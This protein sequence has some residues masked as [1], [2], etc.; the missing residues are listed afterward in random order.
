MS[1]KLSLKI[2]GEKELMKMFK[3]LGN[4]R[5]RIKA[6]NSFLRKAARPILKTQKDNIKNS[7][8]YNKPFQVYRK[9]K[10]Y[11]ETTKEQL[12]K[13]VGLL[14]FKGKRKKTIGFALGPRLD[15]V[16]GKPNKGG[17]FGW[18]L[19]YGAD[20]VGKGKIRLRTKPFTNASNTKAAIGMAAMEVMDKESKAIEKTM[21]RFKK[22]YNFN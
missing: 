13:S 1:D 22:N 11:A 18:W 17:W 19:E 21:K 12:A 10:V 3:A 6:L 15:G 14:R 9:G 4:D 20:N 16:W 7:S 5:D 8:T 2:E